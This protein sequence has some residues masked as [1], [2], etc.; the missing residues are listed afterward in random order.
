VQDL[1]TN[2]ST[3]AYKHHLE[4]ILGNLK[5]CDLIYL[6]CFVLFLFCFDFVFKKKQYLIFFLE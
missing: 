3:F 5:V 2:I 4:H 6:F 1:L